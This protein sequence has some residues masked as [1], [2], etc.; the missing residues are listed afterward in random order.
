MASAL[1]DLAG[2]LVPLSVRRLPQRLAERLQ[3]VPNRPEGGCAP[4][5]IGWISLRNLPTT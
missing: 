1:A 4:K 5:V 3:R 2:A